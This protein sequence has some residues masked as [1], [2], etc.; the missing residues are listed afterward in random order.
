MSDKAKETAAKEMP[1]TQ[2]EKPL[3]EKDLDEVSGG[4]GPLH[5]GTEVQ[6]FRKAE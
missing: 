3:T 6:S 2:N 4:V 1:K 5:P